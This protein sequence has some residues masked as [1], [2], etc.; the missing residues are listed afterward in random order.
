M[1]KLNYLASFLIAAILLS[2]CG[3]LN[4]MRDE[5]GTLTFTTTPQVLEMHGGEVEYTIEG[6]I[7]PDWFNEDAIVEIGRAHV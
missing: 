5:Y 2:S 6:E 1:K 7:P 3:G 4:K